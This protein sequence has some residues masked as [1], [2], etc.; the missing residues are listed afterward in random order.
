MV[1]SRE[2]GAPMGYLNH[3]PVKEFFLVRKV[4]EP[5][6]RGGTCPPVDN[7]KQAALG[8]LKRGH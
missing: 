1:N 2:P 7:K 3:Q 5:S 4:H 6:L 8:R